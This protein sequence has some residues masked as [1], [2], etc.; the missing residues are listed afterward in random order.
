[1][2][3][4]SVLYQSDSLSFITEAVCPYHSYTLSLITATVCPLSQR[5]SVLITATVCPLSQPRYSL[6]FITATPTTCVIATFHGLISN[7]SEDKFLAQMDYR[8]V[9]VHFTLSSHCYSPRV[10]ELHHT[11]PPHTR[12]WDQ[13]QQTVR[14]DQGLLLP[15]NHRHDDREEQ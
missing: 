12:T 1:M 8:Q 15:E 6:S 4:L 2:Y 9:D 14:A 10:L 11:T 7:D 13:P 3:M 5:Q